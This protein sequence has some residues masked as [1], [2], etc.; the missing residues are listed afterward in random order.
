MKSFLYL[1]LLIIAVVF[2]GCKKNNDDQ[3]TIDLDQNDI[4]YPN[5]D[6]KIVALNKGAPWELADITQW[7]TVYNNI[8]I[9][10]FYIGDIADDRFTLEE[11]QKFI[12]V[13][14]DKNIKIAIESGG[15]IASFHDEGNQA[16]ELS[17]QK[18]FQDIELLLKPIS[19]GGLGGYLDILNFDAPVRRM[20]YPNK[21]S[22]SPF[23]N[24]DMAANEFV[25]M[26]D[27]W[28]GVFPNIEINYV[29]S[30][31]NWGWKGEVAYN[32]KPQAQEEYGFG[33]YHEIIS[34][35]IEVAN[36]NNTKINGMTLANGY[37]Y[38]IGKQKSNQAHVIKDMDWLARIRDIEQTVKNNGWN[39][40]LSLN[41]TDVITEQD[42]ETIYDEKYF[43]DAIAFIDLYDSS[44][45]SAD[46]YWVQTWAPYPTEWLPETKDY[47]MTNTAKAV[48]EKVKN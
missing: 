38:A 7:A 6:N 14:K 27:L 8:D 2:F 26:V 3:L 17:F 45:G 39:F 18:D 20:L 10:Q 35:V 33:D 5:P 11:K 40:Y 21:T 47:T 25:D 44:G 36:S 43:T 28:R 41:N 1:A 42:E 19:E 48:L 12:K 30:F 9:Y 16:G 4:I 37:D 13:L 24:L 29:P 22:P 31:P 15:L 32:N 46:G 34:K 23:Q